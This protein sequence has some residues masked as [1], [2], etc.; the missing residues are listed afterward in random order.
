[1]IQFIFLPHRF[2][3]TDL[4]NYQRRLNRGGGKLFVI[5][6]RGCWIHPLFEC[7]SLFFPIDPEPSEPGIRIRGEIEHVCSKSIYLRTSVFPT[8]CS[9]VVQADG[10][11][12]RK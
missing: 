4:E 5:E 9:K 1:M 12:T 10:V 3:T 8:R 6:R 7:F 11:G 2:G